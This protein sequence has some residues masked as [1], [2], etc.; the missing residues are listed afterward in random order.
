MCLRVRLCAYSFNNVYFASQT[1]NWLV[2]RPCEQQQK[3]QASGMFLLNCQTLL[4]PPAFPV[5]FF[6]FF[7]FVYFGETTK[8]RIIS[9]P[10]FLERL[11]LT[12]VVRMITTLRKNNNIQNCID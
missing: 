7:P 12:S 3:A 4:M 2:S 5:I 11:P 6:V 1:I 8:S 9:G 10:F